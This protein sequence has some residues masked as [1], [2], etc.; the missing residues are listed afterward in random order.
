MLRPIRLLKSYSADVRTKSKDM[1][2]LF[3]EV[4]ALGLT[5]VTLASEDVVV[6]DLVCAAC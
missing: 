6:I 5:R 2:R 1:A 3:V 4:L